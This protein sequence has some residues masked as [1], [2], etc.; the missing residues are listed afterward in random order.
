MFILAE[1]FFNFLSSTL[2]KVGLQR[3]KQHV[4]QGCLPRQN[5]LHAGI[6]G[7]RYQRSGIVFT[8]ILTQMLT[9]FRNSLYLNAI[10][11][12][13][14]CLFVFHLT[15]RLL[16]S[17][18][19]QTCH[20]CINNDIVIGVGSEL[21]MRLFYYIHLGFGAKFLTYLGIEP[22][23]A[24]IGVVYSSPRSKL[25]YFTLNRYLIAHYVVII[26][27]HTKMKRY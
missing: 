21:L 27:F 22:W 2:F 10:T 12:Y 7:Q 4:P 26:L 25:I 11:Q 20:G 6:K 23:P 18:Q 16:Q 17:I 15:I 5:V 8:N 24:R 14:I 3:R 1:N 13:T 19:G 9:F